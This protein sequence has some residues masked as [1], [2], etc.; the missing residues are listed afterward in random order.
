MKLDELDDRNKKALDAKQI[1]KDLDTKDIHGLSPYVGLVEC[2]NRPKTSSWLMLLANTDDMVAAKYFYSGQYEQTSITLWCALVQHSNMVLDIGSHTGVY[3]L[4][5]SATNSSV[6]IFSIEPV[7]Q[8]VYRQRLN[9]RANGF[10]NITVIQAAASKQTGVV[11]LN[12]PDLG[13]YLTQGASLTS[14]TKS[15]KLTQVR[16][17]SI[18][19]SIQFHDTLD[20]VKIDAEGGEIEAMLGMKH[21]IEKHLPI[22]LFECNDPKICKP[23]EKILFDLNYRIFV[24][25][26]SQEE[27][28]ETNA[29]TVL[30]ERDGSLARNLMNRIA[31]HKDKITEF[32]QTLNQVDLK[33]RSN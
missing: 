4:A 1:G 21:T 30:R 13:S 19:K 20:L 22:I 23:V 27:F 24:I 17:I 33:V 11:Q 5:A 26:E 29:L 12:V 6:K 32:I 8:N 2:S 28:D 14:K 9:I 18:D 7:A 25:D 16:G 3:S 10:T 31:V 15:S